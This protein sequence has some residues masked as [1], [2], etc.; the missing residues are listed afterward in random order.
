MGKLAAILAAALVAACS[1]A[2]LASTPAWAVARA[3]QDLESLPEANRPFTRYV[4]LPDSGDKQRVALMMAINHGLSRAA[5]PITFTP[6]AN[7]R[8]GVWFIEASLARIDL[9]VIGGQSTAHLVEVWEELHEF[10]PYFNM[11]WIVPN[12]HY[13]AP[14]EAGKPDTR[15]ANK[16][17]RGRRHTRYASYLD[18]TLVK[19]LWAD[20]QSHAG[21]TFSF[22]PIVRSD[23]LVEKSLST[24]NGNFYY[25]FRGLTKEIKLFD[26]LKLRGVN[27]DNVKANQKIIRA[28][29]AK[30]NPTKS[31]GAIVLAPTTE[32]SPT[33][34]LVGVTFDMF[35]ENRGDPDYDPERNLFGAPKFDA[36]ETIVTLE[37]GLHEFALWNGE[38]VLQDEAP[39]NAAADQTF[40]PHDLPRLFP[41]MSCLN[42]H[43]QRNGW[44]PL[45]DPDSVVEIN[46]ELKRIPNRDRIRTRLD[47]KEDVIGDFSRR[48]VSGPET[49]DK[50]AG[51][52]MRDYG[53]GLDT[54]RN[55]YADAV[56]L[57]TGGIADVD[58]STASAWTSDVF[59]EYVSVDV[60]REQ[61]ALE[62]GLGS[63]DALPRNAP[64]DKDILGLFDGLPTNRRNWE[65]AYPDAAARAATRWFAEE[66]PEK[67]VEQPPAE[68]PKP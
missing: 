32:F 33:G 15:A 17:I 30:R 10:E 11:H 24:V 5:T 14:P 9:A 2:C 48:D 62:L 4:W 37:N 1:T 60:T 50:L 34:G 19:K 6:S 16:K 20:Y 47:R 66:K 51:L 13:K 56:F 46:G 29:I 23:W 36:A 68:Q 64:E 59:R 49:F 27:V 18:K 52:Y 26:Y 45:D 57:V 44:L 39:Q 7:G 43:G 22:V 21:A 65:N 40:L 41:A 61:A 31:P 42:C 54:A 3:V 58:V 8:Q 67:P 12:E 25:R 53:V 38:G 35:A 63:F 28:V 55:V